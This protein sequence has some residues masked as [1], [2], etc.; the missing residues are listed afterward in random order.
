MQIDRIVSLVGVRRMKEVR[1][2]DMKAEIF[3]SRQ[4]SLVV[5]EWSWFPQT[6]LSIIAKPVG[7]ANN[8]ARKIW[9]GVWY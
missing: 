2:L 5:A 6:A 1:P 3:R 8:I 9:L 7:Q 4:H